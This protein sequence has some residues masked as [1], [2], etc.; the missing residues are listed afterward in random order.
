MSESEK[1]GW[2]AGAKFVTVVA[3]VLGVGWLVKKTAETSFVV[4]AAVGVGLTTVVSAAL[5]EEG[6]VVQFP[7]Q[8]APR[9]A[10]TTMTTAA[11]E[12]L[13]LRALCK[14][15]PEAGQCLLTNERLGA[16]KDMGFQFWGPR[17]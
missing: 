3:A 12:A 13:A 1:Y 6:V 11:G 5:A 7:R 15:G 2:S 14:D 8:R 4:G 10:G 9:G 16:L 17:S